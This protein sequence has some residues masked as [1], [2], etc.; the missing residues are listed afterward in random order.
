MDDLA[1]DHDTWCRYHTEA[2]DRRLVGDLLDHD[3][4][5]QGV[6]GVFDQFGRID[7]VVAAR[8]VWS[9]SLGGSAR[10]AG[11][12]S[13]FRITSVAERRQKTHFISSDWN[14]SQ[15]QEKMR[16]I[17]QISEVSFLGGWAPR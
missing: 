5:A 15:K 2:E 17:S 10:A 9:R 12:M 4:T 6:G 14:R 13:T 16:R 3:R 11:C 7:A 1:V 8:G